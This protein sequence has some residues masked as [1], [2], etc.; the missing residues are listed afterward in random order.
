MGVVSMDGRLRD[1]RLEDADK[2]SNADV[3]D[4]GVWVTRL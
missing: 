4:C 3:G 2:G 1:G